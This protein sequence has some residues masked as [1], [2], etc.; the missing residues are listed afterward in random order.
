MKPME[1]SFRKFIYI[2]GVLLL[3]V[4]VIRF[5]QR[6]SEMH[7]LEDQLVLVQ[8]QG[9]AVV[10]TQSNLLTQVAFANSDEAVK[11]WAYRDGRWYLPYETPIIVLSDEGA[12][13]SKTSQAIEQIEPIHNWQVWLELFFGGNN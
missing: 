13:P 10:Q 12:S 7:Q 9:T 6:V 3:T 11:E 4:I 1:G 8:A 2:A 5:Q